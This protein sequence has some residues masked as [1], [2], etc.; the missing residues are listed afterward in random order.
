MKPTRRYSLS[1]LRRRGMLGVGIVTAVALAFAMPAVSAY[2]FWGASGVGAGSGST[3]TLLAPTGVVVP[4]T[5]AGAVG[6]NWTASAGSTTPDGYYVVRSAGGVSTAACGSSPAALL[7][8]ISCLDHV[9]TVGTYTYTV[10]A[11]YQSW[12]A[13]SDPSR[14]VTVALTSQLAF[15][16]G[17]TDTVAGVAISPAVQVTVESSSGSTVPAAGVAITVAISNNPASG[18][19]S[20]TLTASTNASGVATFAGLAIDVAASGYT[21]VATSSGL[22]SA[23]SPAFT[24]LAPSLAAPVLG[25]AASYSVL[26]TAA[27]N[28]GVTTI[29]G[30]LGAYS[31]VTVTGFPNG[32]VQGVTD[33][34]DVASAGADT[35][36]AA[37]YADALSRTPDTQFAG[38]LIGVTFTPG[39]HHTGAALALSAGGVLT[40]DAQG[41]PNAV[42]IFQINGAL[43]TAAGSSVQLI[44]G[45]QA[46]NVFWQVNG[47]AGTGASSS[48]SGTILA[49]GA[50]TLGAGSTLIGRAL[51]AGAVTLATNTIRFTVALPPTISINGGST[52]AGSATTPSFSGATSAPPG[53]AVTVY[54][55]NQTL[56]T[57]VG[58]TGTWSVTATS[59]APGSYSVLARV[60][61]VAGNATTATQ[62]AT[63]S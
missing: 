39:V 32:T 59:V 24:V 34:D 50:I 52:T 27:T 38:D 55:S 35:D 10:V 13:T 9:S 18:T 43:N 4:S 14:A 61:D 11:V 41:N 58:P 53:Q 15:S 2:G 46:S 54:V 29:S 17:P 45:A 42:F 49:A 25:R 21:L 51:S 37:A 36:F 40:L 22:T 16:V 12:I 28:G 62:V 31:T 60:R 23:T 6:V 63:L 33:A 7:S 1:H 56:T 5:S 48:F 47:A 26:G 44:N 30:D 8:T 20:G 3:G 19:L 57:T